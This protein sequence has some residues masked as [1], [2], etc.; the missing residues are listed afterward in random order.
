MHGDYIYSNIIEDHDEIVVRDL[1]NQIIRARDDFFEYT[2]TYDG[3]R[4][5]DPEDADQATIHYESLW[6]HFDSWLSK[7]NQDDLCSADR[8]WLDARAKG[9]MWDQFLRLIPSIYMSVIDAYMKDPSRLNYIQRDPETG[10]ETRIERRVTSVLPEFTDDDVR[11][12]PDRASDP[13]GPVPS[14]QLARGRV[15]QL[16]TGAAGYWPLAT[17][18]PDVADGRPKLL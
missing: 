2:A 10:K 14:E 6:G 13:R 8:L 1:T 7:I 11:Y 9:A 4:N 3:M 18:G 16:V 15:M 12:L 5:L 17:Y